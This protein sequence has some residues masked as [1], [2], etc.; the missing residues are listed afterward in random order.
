MWKDVRGYKGY[1]QVNKNGNIRSVTRTI[2]DSRGHVYTLKSRP[3][4]PEVTKNGYL[5][6]HLCKNGKRKALYV[7]KIVAE[8]FILNI[9]WKPVV[10]HKDGNKRRCCSSNLEWYTYSQNNQ[11]AYNTGLKSKG[12]GHYRAILTRK[13]VE[14]IK[15]NGKWGTYQN[16]A[17]VYGVSKAT[18]RDILCNRTW[19]DV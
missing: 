6:V 10:N 3:I 2:T 17:D 14:E 12:E 8:A 7:H 4:I 13:T 1:Y 9:G 15:K 16:I 5:M 18:I 11:H 19:T